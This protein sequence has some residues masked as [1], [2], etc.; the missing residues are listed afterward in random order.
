MCVYGFSN[1]GVVWSSPILGRLLRVRAD[2]LRVNGMSRVSICKFTSLALSFIVEGSST[3][4]SY[5]SSS[6]I[7]HLETET[8]PSTDL[9]APTP[10]SLSL[11]LRLRKIDVAPESVF[12]REVLCVRVPLGRRSSVGKMSFPGSMASMR[13]S[14]GKCRGNIYRESRSSPRTCGGFGGSQE[15]LKLG[16]N[17][18]STPAEFCACTERFPEEVVDMIEAASGA[19]VAKEETLPS[20]SLSR[21]RSVIW[22]EIDEILKDAMSSGTPPCVRLQPPA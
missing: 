4:S 18:G 10:T 19:E 6:G 20:P 12:W 14:V 5:S 7:R 1:I 21:S 2:G 15:C 13:G 16:S 17:N 11:L 9:R 8:F 3:S 22:R